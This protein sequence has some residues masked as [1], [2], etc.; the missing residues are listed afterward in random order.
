MSNK[1]F[2]YLPNGPFFTGHKVISSKITYDKA[3][4]F[5]EDYLC[6]DGEK[7]DRKKVSIFP[8]RQGLFANTR[9]LNNGFIFC[10]NK[11]RINLFEHKIYKPR[12]NYNGG[13]FY[14][15]YELR[16]DYMWVELRCF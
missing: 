9:L 2:V 11:G 10:V 1:E 7:Y 3:I 15:H 16:L 8:N 5:D 4:D 6:V 14:T 13:A 12:Y